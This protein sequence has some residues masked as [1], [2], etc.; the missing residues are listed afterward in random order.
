MAAG[1]S[2]LGVFR[3]LAFGFAIPPLHRM[4][5]RTAI[6]GPTIIIPAG[7][8]PNGVPFDVQL[9]DNWGHDRGHCLCC[10]RRCVVVLR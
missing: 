8:G 2:P 7:E 9:I 4:D 5:A 1:T 6:Y 3:R 10:V